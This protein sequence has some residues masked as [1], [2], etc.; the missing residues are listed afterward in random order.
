[1]SGILYHEVLVNPEPS[2]D[3]GKAHCWHR[4]WTQSAVTDDHECQHCC[5]CNHARC[6]TFKR[7]KDP[8]HG[9][10]HLTY[11]RTGEIEVMH[12]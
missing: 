5:W 7:E 8:N 2:C 1:M 4:S 6:L 10:H 9:P 12:K 3:P 11:R